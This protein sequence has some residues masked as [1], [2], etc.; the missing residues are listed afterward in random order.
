MEKAVA[1]CRVDGPVSE[2]T[3]ELLN[4]QKFRLK[5]YAQKHNIEITDFYEDAGFPGYTLE[6]P[7]LQRLMSDAENGEISTVLAVNHNRLFRGQMPQRLKA[8]QLNIHSISDHEFDIHQ[9]L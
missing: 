5:A 2:N 6:R 4:A 3:Q 8:L 7:G 1:Y 9:G